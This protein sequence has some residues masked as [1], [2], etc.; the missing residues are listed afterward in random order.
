MKKPPQGRRSHL[1]QALEATYRISRSGIA[2]LCYWCA[3]RSRRE[4][5]GAWTYEQHAGEPSA[6]RY[7]RCGGDHGCY[8]DRAQGWSTGRMRRSGISRVASS[9]CLLPKF[10]RAARARMFSL[11]QSYVPVLTART[12]R[13]CVLPDFGNTGSAQAGR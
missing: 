5:H 10:P 12:S 13:C 9:G 7:V 6:V 4:A 3:S 1:A 8:R 11:V 2:A